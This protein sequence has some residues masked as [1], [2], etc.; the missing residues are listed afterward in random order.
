MQ[1][2]ID[3]ITNNLAFFVGLFVFVVFVVGFVIAMSTQ[4]GRDALGR[5]AVR[6]AVTAL[7]FAEKWLGREI[8]GENLAAIDAR[9]ALAQHPIV[10]AQ[11]ELQSWLQQQTRAGR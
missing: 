9:Q 1:D 4:A 7:G 5:A 3:L 6:F 10:A 2:F 8:T 11:V